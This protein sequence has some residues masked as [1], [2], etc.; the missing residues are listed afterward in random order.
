M[1]S[2]LRLA[3]KVMTAY[4]IM[5]VEIHD[6]ARFMEYMQQ[7]RPL[8]DAA[9]A[10][11][12]ARGG[13]FK[14]VEGDYRPKRLLLLEFPSMEAIDRFCSSEEYQAL[15]SERDR[16]SVTCLIALSGSD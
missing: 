11:Y 16:C 9:G 3:V 2:R 4:A 8:L 12:L 10:R 1:T 5:D 6:I 7:V 13:E 14:V 15:R